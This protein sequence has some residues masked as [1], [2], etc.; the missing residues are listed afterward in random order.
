MLQTEAYP[1]SVAS[2]PTPS[3]AID[4]QRLLGRSPPRSSD[5]TVHAIYSKDY[6]PSPPN[7]SPIQLR[8]SSRKNL[9][10]GRRTPSPAPGVRRRTSLHRQQQNKDKDDCSMS[11]PIVRNKRGDVIPSILRPA[12]TNSSS[13]LPSP[14]PVVRPALK[15]SLTFDGKIERVVLFERGSLPADISGSEKYEV[16]D[17]G[18]VD[19]GSV[20]SSMS[21]SETWT[22]AGKNLP[23]LT[24]FGYIPVVLDSI[25]LDGGKRLVGTILVRNL[26]FEKSVSVRYTVDGWA[27]AGDLDAEYLATVSQQH[28]E[29]YGVDRFGFELDLNEEMELGTATDVKFECAINYVVAGQSYWDNNGGENYRV[30]L[31][32]PEHMPTRPVPKSAMQAPVRTATVNAW[33]APAARIRQQRSSKIPPVTPPLPSSAPISITFPLTAEQKREQR[34]AV[35]L[36]KSHSF[37][38]S[39]DRYSVAA[40]PL[41]GISGNSPTG[42][43]SPLSSR[44]SSFGPIAQGTPVN[45]P[46]SSPRLY[47]DDS[48]F[49]SSLACSPPSTFAACRA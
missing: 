42:I 40:E 31:R 1:M 49:P 8:S 48:S 21:L 32:R 7:N 34:R 30:Q 43:E 24:A 18:D 13:C 25:H 6:P 45:R 17:S 41:P 4:I 11:K 19:A 5:F 38:G 29:F 28:G 36:Q 39:F 37:M 35:S 22:I 26:A 23:A 2:P 47:A 16:H 20:S 46:P 9:D 15:K 10:G 3:Y 27:T 44:Y 12:R 33:D 14:T